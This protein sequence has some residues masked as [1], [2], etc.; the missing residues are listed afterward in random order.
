MGPFWIVLRA[1]R[2]GWRSCCFIHAFIHDA[3]NVFGIVLCSARQQ[4]RGHKNCKKGSAVDS[5]LP[6]RPLHVELP[7]GLRT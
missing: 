5:L 3:W 7:T 2:V 4:R 1:V 6:C